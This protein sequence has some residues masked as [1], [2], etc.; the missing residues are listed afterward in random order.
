MFLALPCQGRGICNHRHT[1]EQ[2]G[3]ISLGNSEDSSLAT[4]NFSQPSLSAL[5]RFN[6]NSIIVI[7]VAEVAQCGSTHII[8]F[9]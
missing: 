8:A 3:L 2:G 4:S 9:L 6:T 5:R 1:S 7:V